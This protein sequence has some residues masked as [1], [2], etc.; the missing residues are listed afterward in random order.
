[1]HP[2]LNLFNDFARQKGIADNTYIVGGAVRDM[3]SGIET[4]DIDLAVAGDALEISKEFAEFSGG[5]FVLLDSEFL[6]A[7]VV[8]DSFFLDISAMK[9]DSI[10]SDLAGRD[11]TINAMAQSLHEWPS[12]VRVIDP[13][14]GRQDLNSGII[15]MVSE[16]NLESDPLRIL[17]IYRFSAAL[18]ASIEKNTRRVLKGQG[19][20]LKNVAAERIAEELRHIMALWDSHETMNAMEEDNVIYA[21]FPEFLNSPAI[22][23]KH[24]ILCYRQCESMLDELRRYFPL[25]EKHIYAYFG[26]PARRICLKLAALFSGESH[27]QEAAVR[28]KM[29]NKET[30]LVASILTG[31]KS[32]MSL[33]NASAGR[34]ELVRFLKDTRD[35]VYPVAIL[36][37]A[38]DHVSSSQKIPLSEN[39]VLSFSD[40]ILSLY[41]DDVMPRLGL[42]RMIT[43]DD[44]INEFGLSPSPQFKRVLSELEDAIL[45][46]K[47]KTREEALEAVRHILARG[48]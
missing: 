36:A 41:S 19:I 5:T 28:M 21:L 14:G 43:G 30:G 12:T 7:R 35:N 1:M 34:S 3:L 18:H 10:I 40:K 31:Y 45:E 25:H 46:G 17:R 13:F 42:L 6:I 38:L 2:L 39:R 11:I 22:S 24:G 44:L 26:L 27:A 47:V 15:R 33:L 48:L 8:K 23:I 20:L 4:N 29:S 37:P 32:I 9:G 16:K